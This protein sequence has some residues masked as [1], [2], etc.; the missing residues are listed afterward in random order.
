[1]CALRRH[2][3]KSKREAMSS[4]KP[5]TLSPKQTQTLRE[6]VRTIVDILGGTDVL[7]TPPPAYEGACTPFAMR[8]VEAVLAKNSGESLNVT[9]IA[10]ESGISAEVVRQVLYL[11]EHHKWSIARCDVNGTN[12]WRF[13]AKK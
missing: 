8:M 2:A 10:A 4:E 13:N 3:R 1:V 7:C 6:S 11:D 9:R 5:L 12:F